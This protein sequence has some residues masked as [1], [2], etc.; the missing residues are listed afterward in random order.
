M[1]QTILYETGKH[2]KLAPKRNEF[3]LKILA[4]HHLQYR[5]YST[6]VLCAGF[7]SRRSLVIEALALYGAT[8][9]GEK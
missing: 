8:P 9:E 6:V 4:P 5:L 7:F 1:L 2:L 3:P